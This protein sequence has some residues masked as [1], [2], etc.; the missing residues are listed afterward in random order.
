[1][2]IVWGLFVEIIISEN[3]LVIVVLKLLIDD[4]MFTY[5]LTTNL[6]TQP[7]NS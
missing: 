6:Y 3:N 7:N 2:I 4:I 1:M 5:P